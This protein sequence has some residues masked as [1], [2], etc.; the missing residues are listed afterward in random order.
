MMVSVKESGIEFGEFDE[1]RLFQI[2]HSDIHKKAGEGI[3]SVEFIYLT[4]KDNIL[5]VEAKNSC[6]NAANK[7]ENSDKQRKYEEYYSEIVDKFVDSLNMFVATALGRNEK[8]ACVGKYIREKHTYTRTGFKFVLVIAGAEE[9]WLGGPKAELE[10]RLLRIRK[11][12]NADVVVLNA[13]MAEKY[14]LVKKNN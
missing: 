10:M 2:E 13:Q 9:S 5:F 8:N 14:N 1:D 11:I 3:K 4:R 6:P 7:D 12:W